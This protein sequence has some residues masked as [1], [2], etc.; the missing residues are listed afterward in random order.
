MVK[1]IRYSLFLLSLIILS[2]CTVNKSDKEKNKLVEKEKKDQYRISD[3]FSD[4]KSQ[5]ID[6]IEGD[7]TFD[8]RY[9]GNTKFIA[10]LLNSEG[11]IVEILAESDGPYKGVK[12]IKVPKT[13][14]YILDVK[15]TG[16]WSI[17]KR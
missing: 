3:I 11:D 2:S 7:A 10:R 8:I 12:S 16:N 5:I 17:S 1:I 4:N 13:T 6:L 15:T 14:S 9:E